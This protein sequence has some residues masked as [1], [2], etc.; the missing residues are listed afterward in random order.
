MKKNYLILLLLLFLFPIGIIAQPNNSIDTVP[1][2]ETELNQNSQVNFDYDE[3]TLDMKSAFYYKTKLHT[4]RLL[5]NLFLIAFIFMIFVVGF[6]FY[7]YYSKTKEVLNLVKIQE[8]E[9]ELRQFEVKKLGIILNNTEDSS[10]IAD[11]EGN[12][13]WTNNSFK[14]IFGYTFEELKNQNKANIFL[15]SNPEIKALHEKCINSLKPIQYS[16]ETIDNKD[17]QVWFQRRIIPLIDEEK[18]EII[19]FAVID[20]DFTALKLAMKK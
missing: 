20:T 16:T 4:Q 6:I 10:L 19:N 5:K 7:I 8:K 9:I 18:K 2:S 13:I 11:K 1:I 12:I 15:T 17:N 3:N 14:N